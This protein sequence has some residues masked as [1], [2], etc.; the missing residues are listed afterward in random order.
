LEEKKITEL[1]E[2]LLEIQSGGRQRSRKV[3]AEDTRLLDGLRKK[4]R[5][6][7]STTLPHA[8]EGGSHGTD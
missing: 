5:A 4:S 3:L 8:P 7:D 6:H 1:I 2:R